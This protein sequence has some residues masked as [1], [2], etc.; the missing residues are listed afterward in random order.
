MVIA[1]D[2]LIRTVS[3]IGKT[4]MLALLLWPAFGVIFNVPPNP[5]VAVPM[6]NPRQAQTSLATVNTRGAS[7]LWLILLVIILPCA[8][9]CAE[10][11][12]CKLADGFDHAVGKPNAKGYHK[13]RGFSPNGHMGEDWNGDGGGDS[14][15]GDPIYAIGHGVVVFSDN[16]HVGWGNVIIIRH[17][18]R[19]SDGRINMVDSLYGHLL[20]RKAKVGDVV[21]R[22]QLIATMGSNN[23][24]YPAHL[25]L[26]VHKNLVMGLNR[27][28]FAHDYSNYY[29][30]TPFI[31]GHR[32]LSA[33]FGKYDIP[34][35][36]SS[37]G[38]TVT[39]AQKQSGKKLII[40]VTKNPTTG[41]SKITITTTT[42]PKDTK[43]S[44]PTTPATTTETKS[45]FWS[46]LR[47]KLKEGQSTNVDEGKK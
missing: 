35:E 16:V 22:G 11:V 43:P 27:S 2:Y 7:C 29:S 23:G 14:D 8:A 40:P 21:E 24:M 13:A 46:R 44:A 42:I 3:C 36:I 30:P 28:Q 9:R 5:T 19:E 41:P 17:A 10:S 4:R 6:P 38:Q 26:E 1:K 47:T 37:Y 12:R 15:L 20:E 45:D 33:D 39:E 32:R 31:E 25:H 34:L 18:F